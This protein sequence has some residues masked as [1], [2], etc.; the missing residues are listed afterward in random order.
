MM[1]LELEGLGDRILRALENGVISIRDEEVRNWSRETAYYFPFRVRDLAQNRTYTLCSGT[2]E[3]RDQWISALFD[4]KQAYVSSLFESETEPFSLKVLSGNGEET[5][6]SSIR[7]TWNLPKSPLNRA[8]SQVEPMK[9][10]DIPVT[11]IPTWGKPSTGVRAPLCATTFNFSGSKYLAQGTSKGFSIVDYK[12]AQN[13]QAFRVWIELPDVT[14]LGAMEDHNILLVLAKRVLYT[15]QVDLICP[16]TATK[17]RQKQAPRPL[18]A[19]QMKDVDFFVAGLMEKKSYIFL[20]QSYQMGNTIMV[21][22]LGR[23]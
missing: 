23:S 10:G 13:L 1:F 17:S 15:Y 18:Q 4:A 9:P 12:S 16:S 6:G 14:Q 11:R 19:I 8:L 21:R 2:S 3:A 20:S 5:S 7:K 22:L